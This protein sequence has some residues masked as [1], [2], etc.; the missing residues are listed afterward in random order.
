M[1]LD[2]VLT[3]DRFCEDAE[4]FMVKYHTD[5]LDGD[6]GEIISGKSLVHINLAKNEIY[7]S[8][9]NKDGTSLFVLD[10]LPHNSSQFYDNPIKVLKDNLE[11]ARTVEKVYPNIFRW[12]YDAV[13]VKAIAIIPSGVSKETTTIGRY[14][15]TKNFIR[16]IRQQ[17]ENIIS[18]NRGKSPNYHF[19]EFESEVEDSILSVGSINKKKDMYFVQISLADSASDILRQ[20][21]VGKQKYV[22]LTSLE[23]KYWAKEINPDVLSETKHISLNDT[24]SIDEGWTLYPSPIKNLMMLN[25]KGNY[26]RFLLIRFLLSVH[27]SRDAK[28]VYYS[29]LSDNEREHVETGNCSNQW[30]YVKN[31]RERYD[32]PTNKELSR[33][34]DNSYT[35]SHPLEEIEAYLE[36]K[37]V[38][39]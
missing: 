13:S 38:K 5:S 29:V 28:F 10:L 12:F 39:K 9:K 31:N 4:Y 37:K 7:R 17:L 11:H 1:F 26:N 8:I 34:I 27:N 35:L 16:V 6:F 36:S 14:G 20:S 25:N 19:L 18:M 33:F 24:L 22:P 15:G 21:L 2:Q 3:I 30:G 32:C 23:V